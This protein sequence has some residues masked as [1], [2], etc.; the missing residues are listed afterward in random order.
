MGCRER[1]RGNIGTAGT[2]PSGIFTAGFAQRLINID[3]YIPGKHIVIIGSGD[4]GLIMARRCTWIGSKVHG[5]VEILPYPSGLSRNISQCLNDFR[6]PL[7]LSHIVTKIYGKNR[8]EGVDISP[9][10]DR[11][12]DN[13]SSD[14][15]K[16]FSI[17]CDTILLSVGLIPENELSKKMGVAIN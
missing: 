14:T 13:G 16:S 7:Y 4:I 6:I 10:A 17:E 8:V 15:S 3:G 1:N 11:S 9:L 12:S 2:R 5:V